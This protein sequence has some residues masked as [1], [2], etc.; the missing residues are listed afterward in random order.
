MVKYKLDLKRTLREIDTRSLVW[1]DFMLDEERKAFSPYLMMRY[2]ASNQDTNP[3]AHQICVQGVNELVN[4]NFDVLSKHPKLFWMLLAI[5]G[6]GSVQFHPWL[7]YKTKKSNKKSVKFL[8]DRYPTMK[9]DDLEM[10]AELN[11][12]KDLRQWAENLGWD[13]KEI[14]EKL[15]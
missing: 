4:K 11:D 7:N 14:K 13:K 15:G 2:A 3:L 6:V 1:Y 12:V 9:R 5:G 8:E 10:M